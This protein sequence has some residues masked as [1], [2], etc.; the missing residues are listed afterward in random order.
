MNQGI[1]GLDLIKEQYRRGD[2]IMNRFN[3]NFWKKFFFLA[4]LWNISAGPLFVALYLY[5]PSMIFTPEGL[6]Y[7]HNPAFNAFYYVLIAAIV[8]FGI[9]YY[10]PSR[11]LMS[12]RVM[13][14]LGILGKV[15]LTIVFFHLYFAKYITPLLPVA[16][17]GDLIWAAFFYTFL[18]QTRERVKVSQF[19]G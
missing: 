11:D 14:W 17:V 3:D 7:T 8:L 6:T 4:S 10:A 1:C 18:I 15:F 13:V 2:R 16:L 5:I 9:G 19:V 12:N